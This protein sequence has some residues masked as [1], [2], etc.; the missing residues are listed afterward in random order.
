M[1]DSNSSTRKLKNNNNNFI[2][3]VLL[4]EGFT[5]AVLHDWMAKKPISA[6]ST[7]FNTH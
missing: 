7:P 5:K 3:Q 1:V 6:L 4:V 2:L